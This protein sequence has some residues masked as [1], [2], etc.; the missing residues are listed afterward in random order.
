[1]PPRIMRM[2]VSGGRSTVMLEATGNLQCAAQGRCV[3]L[4]PRD[5]EYA[6]L[7][8]DGEGKAPELARISRQI[9]GWNILP[10]GQSLAYIPAAAAGP[11]NRIHITSFA[12]Q[13]E[14]DILVENVSGLQNLDV[15]ADGRG[16]FSTDTRTDR[17]RLVFIK[18]DG[19]SQVL[20]APSAVAPLWAISSRDGKNVAIT[21]AVSQRNAWLATF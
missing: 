6:V 16:F 8:L 17:T 3:I 20:W 9:Y 15:L 18:P 21:V 14:R 10:D 4:E 1:M 5:S 12:S 11:R 19:K 7:S 13:P 2:P